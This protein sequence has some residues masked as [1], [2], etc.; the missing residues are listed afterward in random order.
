MSDND[1]ELKAQL[2]RLMAERRSPAEAVFVIRSNPRA[3]PTAKMGVGTLKDI[4]F[5]PFCSVFPH[6]E[7]GNLAEANEQTAAKLVARIRSRD[8]LVVRTSTGRE[9]GLLSR[10]WHASEVAN[11][12]D[13]LLFSAHNPDTERKVMREQYREADY[14]RATCTAFR[15][16][17]DPYEVAAYLRA[18]L[19][20]AGE[21]RNVVPPPLFNLA[22]SFGDMAMNTAPFDIPLANRMITEDGIAVGGWTGR[23]T[24][25]A[26]D[27]F[28]DDPPPQ[29][30]MPNSYSRA[31][32]A[33]GLL[34]MY[35][36]HKE[37]R[38]RGMGGR[39][40]RHHTPLF[41]ISI[42][43]GGPPFRRTLWMAGNED[44]R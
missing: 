15:A 6:I 13:S 11:V 17:D 12:L 5:S 33:D 31:A 36:I 44:D 1:S 38:G 39:A 23:S 30:R 35:V 20:A 14:S 37:A 43:G 21:G 10:G 8:A 24:G 18:W 9:R 3:L 19:A 29:L 28:F 40:R 27:A 4:A 41:G 2:A 32:G 42:P 34:L 16:T 25:W 7:M 26:G 22:V